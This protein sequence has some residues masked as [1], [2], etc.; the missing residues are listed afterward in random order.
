MSRITFHLAE[1]VAF[2]AVAEKLNFRAAAE[3]LFVSQ[4]ALSRRIAKL[5]QA[6]GTRLLERTTQR[7]CLTEAGL[8]VTGRRQLP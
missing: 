2:V 8:G 6:V 7:V 4:P 3:T 1:I 5:E